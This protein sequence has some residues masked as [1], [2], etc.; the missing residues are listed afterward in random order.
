MTKRLLGVIQK[1]LKE[2]NSFIVEL[3]LNDIKKIKKKSTVSIGYSLSFCSDYRLINYTLIKNKYAKLML[4]I[5]KDELDEKFRDMGVFIDED[6]IT[7]KYK[8]GYFVSDLLGCNVIDA[9]DRKQIGTII[10]VYV[11]P[12]NDVWIIETEKGELPV[13]FIDEVIKKVDIKNKKVEINLID[14]LMEL[15]DAKKENKK[16]ERDIIED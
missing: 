7:F 11:L 6:C 8:K 15:C 14:G 9:K 16:V 12:A 10:D 13:P 3:V 4:D 1:V 5:G 2:D